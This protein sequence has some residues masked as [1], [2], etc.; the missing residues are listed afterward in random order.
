MP[1]GVFLQ[2]DGLDR[3]AHNYS[4][5]TLDSRLDNAEKSRL[6]GQHLCNV[7]TLLFA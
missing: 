4:F 7:A 3:F 5:P 2:I 1:R 6:C